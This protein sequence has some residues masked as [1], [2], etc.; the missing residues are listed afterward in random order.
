MSELSDWKKYVLPGL[1][2]EARAQGRAEG[3]ALTHQVKLEE[4]CRCPSCGN[5]YLLGDCRHS[6]STQFGTLYGVCENCAK[7]HADF[8]R[9]MKGIT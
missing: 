8:G 1:L 9:A 3:A 6:S 2:A 5:L 4:T 7:S